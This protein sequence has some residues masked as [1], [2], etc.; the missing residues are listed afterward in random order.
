[1]YHHP[2]HVVANINP[3]N[4]VSASFII[5][6]I[7]S[8][9]CLLLFICHY[10][11]ASKAQSPPRV[12]RCPLRKFSPVYID[13]F[14]LYCILSGLLAGHIISLT[15]L[16]FVILFGAYPSHPY[17]FL[18]CPPM[19]TLILIP[20]SSISLSGSSRGGVDS[21]HSFFCVPILSLSYSFT[22]TFLPP[23]RPSTISASHGGFTLPRQIHFFFPP[24]LVLDIIITRTIPPVISIFPFVH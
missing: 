7:L 15:V 11:N 21:L 24:F 9:H 6:C 3:C 16:G 14:C 23:S 17:T 13:Y 5:P 18:A 8:S 10:Y 22:L 4:S 19:Q 20:H 2:I 12:R 1:M